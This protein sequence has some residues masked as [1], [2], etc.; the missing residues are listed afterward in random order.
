MKV[1]S[2]RIFGY[3]NYSND[4]R[5]T[6]LNGQKFQN[7]EYVIKGAGKEKQTLVIPLNEIVSGKPLT[8][9]FTG[10][11]QPCLKFYLQEENDQQ[12][13]NDIKANLNV[14]EKAVYDLTGRNVT[15]RCFGSGI[16][17]VG[18]RKVILR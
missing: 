12:G 1:K 15:G 4:V 5:V 18:G 9:T 10:D 3:A 13:I 11:N 6:E 14:D 7:D 16:Y 17:I 8:I 2:I